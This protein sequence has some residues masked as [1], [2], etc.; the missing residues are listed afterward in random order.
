MLSWQSIYH[1]VKVL[2]VTG[3]TLYLVLMSMVY[4]RQSSLVYNP[5]HP[6]REI[7]H[8]PA[9]RALAY[10]TVM[11]HTKDNVQLQGWFVPQMQ[12]PYV[13]LIFHGNAGNIS[14]RLDTLEIF[15]RL[16]VSS[17]IFDY[18]GY[19][20]S[21]GE[22]SEQGTYVDAQA[23]WQ[24][25]T[26]QKGYRPE[27]IVIFGRSL[28]GGVASYLAQQRD[29]AA[30]ILESTFTSIPDRGAELYP[31]L[32]IR[33]LANIEYNNLANVEKISSPLLLMH[34]PDDEVIPYTHGRRLFQAANAPKQFFQL[35][36]SHNQGFRITEGYLAALEGF[37][38]QYLAP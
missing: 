17:F 9:E 32:P 33:W 7:V 20:Q 12:S 34:S 3:G 1:Y 4:L 27:Q 36:G 10:E 8:T 38:R 11:L 37:L 6:T 25:L 21:S 2:G 35:V 30:V 22:I 23:A 19:G 16:G 13:V 14:H 31:W 26:Q 24:Y 5:T 29:A 28:G 18:R 15:H